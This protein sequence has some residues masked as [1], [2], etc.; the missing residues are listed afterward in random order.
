[1]K[2]APN[3]A[4]FGPEISEMRAKPPTPTAA[5]EIPCKAL[6]ETNVTGDL[7]NSMNRSK[8]K[9]ITESPVNSSGFRSWNRSDTYPKIA[10]GSIRYQTSGSTYERK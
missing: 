2:L 1:M 5:L 4:L 6:A 10:T 9:I 8:L 7:S 3:A